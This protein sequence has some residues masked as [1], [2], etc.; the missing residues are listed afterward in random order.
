MLREIFYRICNDF[1][2]NILCVFDYIIVLLIYI[3][4]IFDYYDKKMVVDILYLLK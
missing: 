4:L 3:I 1:L 2:I